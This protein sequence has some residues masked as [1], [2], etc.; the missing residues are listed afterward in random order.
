M[1]VGG[2]AFKG[3]GR[4]KKA[5]LMLYP[6]FETVL[7]AAGLSARMGARNK[8]L[9]A[10]DQ[11]PLIRRSASLYCA[12]GMAVTV[13]LGHEADAVE[14]ALEGLPVQT[15]LNADYTSGQQSSIRAGL[16]AAPLKGEALI[17]ALGDQPLL[18]RGDISALCEAY[19]ASAKDKIM[20]PWYK[21]KRGNPAILPVSIAR[22]LRAEDR[23][24]R[25]FMDTNPNLIERYNAP[26]AHFTT[27]IDT[28]E[29][30]DR[31]LALPKE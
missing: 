23:L 11:I 24:P 19:L 14:R 3:S 29:D 10:I 12:L 4:R 28:P 26:N 21:A 5:S 9:L 20:L 18:E 17:M 8:L 30:F 13:V 6:Q 31:F 25:A 1:K 2:D 22:K 7:L 16:S 15:V 27:D